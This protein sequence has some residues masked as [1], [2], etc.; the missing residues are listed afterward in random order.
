MFNIIPGSY[1]FDYASPVWL[2]AS[3]CQRYIGRHTSC[4]WVDG[5]QI[6]KVKNE[7]QTKR[8]CS[9]MDARALPHTAHVHMSKFNHSHP[10]GHL[11]WPFLSNRAPPPSVI[12]PAEGTSGVEINSATKKKRQRQKLH[13]NNVTFTLRRYCITWSTHKYCTTTLERHLCPLFCHII[14]SYY[15][16]E[17]FFFFLTPSLPPLLPAAAAARRWGSSW[18]WQSSKWSR[19]KTHNHIFSSPY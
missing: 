12:D 16:Q 5:A 11:S 18:R 15:Q 10:K 19:L 9:H 6:G 17:V 7:R 13:T 8:R 3:R 4:Y 2:S 1:L 14:T